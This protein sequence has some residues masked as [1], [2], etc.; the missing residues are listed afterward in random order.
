MK[1]PLALIVCLSLLL[2]GCATMRYP[3]NYM[4]EGKEYKEFKELDDE[5][6]LK[7]ITMIYNVKYENWEE[8]TARAIALEE[9]IKLIS[10]R[11]SKYVKASGV[12]DI[13]YDRVD[14]S[15]WGDKDLV[16]LYDAL[17]PKAELY[18]K[19][20]DRSLTEVQNIERIV[21]MTAMN[22]ISRELKKRNN[23]RNAISVGSQILSGVLMIALSI[24]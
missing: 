3:R 13:K 20:S 12:F 17:V 4:V 23:T 2:A 14:I 16:E 21:Y 19:E 9:Y 15:E 22:A 18:Y 5:K 7:V 1:R 24:I 10:K 11:N 6:A 8:E